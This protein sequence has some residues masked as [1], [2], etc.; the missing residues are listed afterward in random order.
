[1]TIVSSNEF[2]ESSLG[3]S[4][5]NYLPP[6]TQ[7]MIIDIKAWDVVQI[8][9]QCYADDTLLEL[10]WENALSGAEVISATKLSERKE[11]GS[12]GGGRETE[13]AQAG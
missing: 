13:T 9:Y 8:Y 3:K 5:A 7:R 2:W 4:L 1:M 10:D 12:D 6:R 11:S